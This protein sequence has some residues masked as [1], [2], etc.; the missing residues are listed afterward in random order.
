LRFLAQLGWLFCVT[1]ADDNGAAPVLVGSKQTLA[2]DAGDPAVDDHGGDD[3]DR[4]ST[5]V[6]VN[7]QVVLQEQMEHAIKLGLI[8]SDTSAV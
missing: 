7:Q 4:G 1:A 8:V 5:T 2:A 3:N 6:A